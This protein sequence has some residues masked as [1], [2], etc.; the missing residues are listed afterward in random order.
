MATGGVFLGGRLT[1]RIFDQLRGPTFLDRFLGKGRMRPL[2]ESMPVQVIL[3]DRT[4]L[5][6]AARYAM[7]AR[8]DV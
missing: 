4:A 6:G 3:N 2:V 8:G 7:L 5:L 1:L